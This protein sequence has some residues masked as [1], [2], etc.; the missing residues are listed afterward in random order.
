MYNAPMR[1]SHS[2]IEATSGL[3]RGDGLA[4]GLRTLSLVRRSAVKA[5]TQSINQIRALVV[6]APQ[7]LRDTAY[8]I[9]AAKCVAACMALTCDSVSAV[10]ASLQ[11]ALRLLAKRW[12]AL[13]KELRELDTQ[14]ARLT[15]KAAPRLLCRFGVGPQTAATLLITA[16]DNLTHLHS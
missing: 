5:K 8:K 2:K 3:T 7:A 11:T 6:S 12:T 9:S 13:N 15:K 4:E 1:M 16:G 14:L 10:L